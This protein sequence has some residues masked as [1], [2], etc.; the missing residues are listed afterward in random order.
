MIVQQLIKANKHQIDKDDVLNSI[1]DLF[2]QGTVI[3]PK[4]Q[5]STGFHAEQEHPYIEED[6]E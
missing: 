1:S 4:W 6:G 3:K 2:I 5:E